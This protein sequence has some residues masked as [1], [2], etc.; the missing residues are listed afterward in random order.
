[1]A[2]HAAAATSEQLPPAGYVCQGDL[3]ADLEDAYSSRLRLI[4]VANL[5]ALVPL[6]IS[7]LLI[8]LP[9]QFYAA[10][11]TPLALLRDPDWPQWAF[12]ALGLV[13][14]GGSL[15]LHEGLHGLALILQGHRP[16]F[17]YE[18]GYPYAAIQPGEFLTRRQ[19]L[20]M[21]LT[22]LT[23]MTLLGV[24]FLVLLPTNIGQIILITLLLNTAAC[25]GDL[26]VADRARR[27]PTT[28]LFAAN[29]EG[30]KVFT[31]IDEGNVKPQR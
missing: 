15:L 17:G 24:V 9:Y 1:M 31:L 28:A 29:N 3:F 23:A 30:I 20:A 25:I 26:A 14:I 2:Q 4:F 18:S 22:P 21:A 5:L 13:T 7:V 10:L 6:G 19:Y 27:W 12:W 11:G 16:K 8:W